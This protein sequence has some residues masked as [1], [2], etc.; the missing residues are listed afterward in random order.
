MS[1]SPSSEWT[2][3]AN[4]ASVDATH[5]CSKQEVEVAS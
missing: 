2:N 3:Q 4:Q 1:P 5:G